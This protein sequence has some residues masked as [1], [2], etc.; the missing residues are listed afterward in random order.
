[1]SVWNMPII[2][3]SVWNLEDDMER[4]VMVVERITLP[5]HNSRKPFVFLDVKKQVQVAEVGY[6]VCHAC[7]WV[8]GIAE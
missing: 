3:V 5:F 7:V 4:L 8:W 6:P 2:D 1:M